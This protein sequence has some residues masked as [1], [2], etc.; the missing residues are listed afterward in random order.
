[1]SYYIDTN[2]NINNIM[3]R[4]KINNEVPKNNIKKWKELKN[5]CETWTE[6]DCRE[7]IIKSLLK[8]CNIETNKKL[9]FLDRCELGVGGNDNN[10]HKQL[11]FRSRCHVEPFLDNDI[12]IDQIYDTNNEKWN[13]EELHD[14]INAFKKYAENYI[15]F[16]NCVNEFIEFK[17]NPDLNYQDNDNYYDKTYVLEVCRFIR[18][19]E[20]WRN[21]GGKQEHVGYM[22]AKFRT[23]EDAC[24]YYNRHNP[25]MRKLNAHN[26]FESDWDPKTELFY[27]VREDYHL[28]DNIPPFSMEDLPIN[29][30]YKFLK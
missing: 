4:F 25:H 1:M 21:K 24:S 13:N 22:K 27:I 12:I 15:N 26:T 9:Q 17:I 20:E 18:N 10:K 19:S 30:E 16:Y 6:T 29:G 14:L 11:R 7:E 28:I 8:Y 23:K 2:E 5:R 3:I